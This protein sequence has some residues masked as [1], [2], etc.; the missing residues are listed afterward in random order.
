[1]AR[2]PPP[3]QLSTPI[4]LVGTPFLFQH[5]GSGPVGPGWNTD[6]FD[7]PHHRFYWIHKGSAR[8]GIAGGGTILLTP[9]NLWLLPA[10]K[11]VSRTATPDFSHTWVNF[12]GPAHGLGPAFSKGLPL[13]SAPVPVNVKSFFAPFTHLQ[14]ASKPRGLREILRASA[15]LLTLFSHTLGTLNQITLGI[16]P[17]LLPFR[18]FILSHL[19]ETCDIRPWAGRAAL[20][21]MYFANLF[22]RN[23]GLPP[24]QW[25]LE[26]RI[27]RA[28]DL[29]WQGASIRETALAVGYDD[30]NYF[31]RLFRRKSGL[32]PGAFRKAGMDRL[33]PGL[34]L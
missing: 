22:T 15:S 9:G 8:M 16:D 27:D 14:H 32:T 1:M 25:Q 29:L 24:G 19:A 26:R 20:D 21:P 13:L 18:D 10:W 30:E 2:L 11:Q 5:G 31:I 28:K 17:R 6:F 12:D 34:K 33:S 3:S 23:L 7:F 4:P